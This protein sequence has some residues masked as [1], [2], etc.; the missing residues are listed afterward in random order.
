MKGLFG[1][2]TLRSLALSLHWIPYEFFSS[3]IDF[4]KH[5]H[6][7]TLSG[8]TKYIILMVILMAFKVTSESLFQ[9]Y[10]F[11]SSSEMQILSECGKCHLMG[12]RRPCQ[13]SEGRG[14]LL[15]LLQP[16]CVNFPS[17]N[18]QRFLRWQETC[19]SCTQRKL[20]WR[21]SSRI[22]I[23]RKSGQD[24]ET[25]KQPLGLPIT[26]RPSETAGKVLWVQ[27]SQYSL[28]A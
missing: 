26:K 1:R 10:I 12:E 2:N 20:A 19:T 4:L 27:V 15:L 11:K 9:H 17:V 6:T 8:L 14:G 24:A 3:V 23:I 7:Y 16:F 22:V 18:L 25:L 28:K 5:T 21:F 13:H